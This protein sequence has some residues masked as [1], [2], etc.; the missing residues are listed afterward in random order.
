MEHRGQE[1][2][3]GLP[4]P[5]PTSYNPS[6]LNQQES[7]SSAANKFLTA[8][9]ASNIPNR[10]T[11]EQN[12]HE[13][14]IFSPN[15]TLDQHNLTQ[16]SDPDPVRQL[17]TSSASERN[18]TPVRYKECLKNHAANM[19]GY[20]RDGCGEFMPSGE[21][22]TPE[23]LK[24]AACDCHRN[25]HRKET[26]DESQTPGVHRNNHRIL[27]QTPPSLPAVP[28]Q[29]QHHHKYSHSYPRGHM[30]P[31]M[32]SFG[33]NTGVAAESSSEDLNMFH[34]GQGIIQPCNFSASKKRFRTKFSQQQ[35]DR[36]LEFAEKLGWR[37]QKQD[38]QEVH[39]FCN[40]VG[41]KRQV[42]KVWMHNSKQ[43]T[44][45]KQT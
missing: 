41:V 29:Q 28:T 16:N 40:E 5:N 2:D 27:N 33:G 12:I 22:E 31:V 10:T 23:Y 19:G 11:N 30:A 8:P 1:K 42:F 36:M 20:V 25:F 21:E 9:I 24:C 45:K 38:E 18:I 37:I 43:A 6:H 7:S 35:K 13:N 32:M 34:G 14:T 44:K 3:M 39:Q 4:N 15:Q 17:S 26:E